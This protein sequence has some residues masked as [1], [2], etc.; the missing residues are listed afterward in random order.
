MTLFS[1]SIASCALREQLA[2]PAEHDEERH[3]DDRQHR[4]HGRAP[5]CQ[6]IE[7]SSTLAPMIRN[8][9]EMIEAIA[10]DDEHLDGVDVG[11]EVASAASPA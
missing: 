2:H 1:Q 9:D 11:G 5:S 8:T 6:L 10:C 3:A 7:S 4:Q